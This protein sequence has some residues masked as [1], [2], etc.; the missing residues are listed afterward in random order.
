[1]EKQLQELQQEVQES[2]LAQS[3]HAQ[4]LAVLQQRHDQQLVDAQVGLWMAAALHALD[5][6]SSFKIIL[7]YCAINPASDRHA[8]MR[9]SPFTE[10]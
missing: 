3:R 10:R 2:R 8:S 5:A 6:V 4:A 7:I 9:C 1:M